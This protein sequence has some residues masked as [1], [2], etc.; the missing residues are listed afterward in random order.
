MSVDETLRKR[1]TDKYGADGNTIA[2]LLQ[3][4]INEG[5]TSQKDIKKCLKKK[6]KDK[7]QDVTAKVLDGT[8]QILGWWVTVG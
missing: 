7:N 8:S 6:L 2:D 3:E 5:N 1:L 4:C